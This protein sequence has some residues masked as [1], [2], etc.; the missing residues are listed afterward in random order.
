MTSVEYLF[1]LEHLGIKLGLEQIRALVDALDR[2]DR[3]FASVIVAGTNGKGSVTAMV[4]RGL[5]ASGL[6]TGRFTSPH[7]ERL[8][9][10][11]AVDGVDID[12]AALAEVASRVRQAAG[13]LPAPPSFFEATTALAF[14]YFRSRRVEAAVVEVGLGGRLDATNVLAPRVAVVTEID[15]D[16]QAYLG[17]TLEAIARE[18]AAVIKAGCTA[19]LAPNVAEAAG[20]VEARCLEVG[21]PLRRVD[22]CRWWDEPGTDGRRRLSVDTGSRHF[23]DVP[24]AL[25]GLHQVRNAVT[26][27]VALEACETF[28]PTGISDAAVRTALTDVVWPGRMERFTWRGHAVIADGAHNPAGARALAAAVADTV[29]RPV[30]FVIGVMADKAIDAILSALAPVASAFICTRAESRRAALPEFIQ[31]RARLVAPAVPASI[32]A[33]PSAALAQAAALGSPVVVAGSLFLVGEVRGL[34][35]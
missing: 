13:A 3:S 17:D 8:N 16:H 31:A 34:R 19:V 18:K 33:T 11:F 24:L 27:V 15:L 20:I 12:D 29:D 10:R 22:R 32:A 4:E 35:D 30:P 7:L 6:R 14:E 26:A 21:A 25:V 9:E 5:R 23:R 1:S 2:P 28:S